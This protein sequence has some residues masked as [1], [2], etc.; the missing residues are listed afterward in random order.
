MHSTR[1]QYEKYRPEDFALYA[2]LMMHPEVMRYITGKPMTRAQAQRR[3]EQMMS[4]N[5][6]H[7]D[8]G[9][10]AVYLRKPRMLVGLAKLVDFGNDQAEAGYALF[11]SFWGQGYASEILKTMM[12]LAARFS[13]FKRLIAVVSPEN[14]ASVRVLEKHGFSFHEAVMNNGDESHH[15]LAPL[16]IHVDNE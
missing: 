2:E 4:D 12:T 13:T 9:W 1:L 10:F 5:A 14:A 16:P 8:T 7:P 15:Y 6:S 3:F 11:P